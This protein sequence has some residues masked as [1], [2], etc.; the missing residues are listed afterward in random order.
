MEK[1]IIT[2]TQQYITKIISVIKG[3]ILKNTPLNVNGRKSDGLVFV[4]SG[5]CYYLTDDKREF[6]AKAGDVIYLANNSFYSLKTGEEDYTFIYCDFNFADEY[7]NQSELYNFLEPN[8]IKHIFNKLHQCF[9]SKN[10]GWLANCLSYLYKIYSIIIENHNKTYVR[11]TWKEKIE[12]A[13]EQ[14][15]DNHNLNVNELAKTLSISQ[16]YFR[17]LFKNVYNICPKEYIILCKVEHAKTLMQY[18][19]ISIEECALESGFSSVQYFCRAFKN[20]V[21]ISPAQYRKKLNQ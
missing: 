19:F 2:K 21:G 11:G 20:T 12:W 1:Y 17:K 15:K 9:I 5:T 7:K 8:Q 13:H 16:V 10:N 4:L 3:K 6:T 14:I 18:P